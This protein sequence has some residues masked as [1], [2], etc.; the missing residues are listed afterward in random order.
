MNKIIEHL[1]AQGDLYRKA[2]R[3]L[4]ED[5]ETKDTDGIDLV[6]VKE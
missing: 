6:E 3:E 2:I 1:H 4:K 5:I